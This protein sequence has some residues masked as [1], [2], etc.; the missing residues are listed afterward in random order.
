MAD[1]LFMKQLSPKELLFGA[2]GRTD[3]RQPRCFVQE[4]Y[5]KKPGNGSPRRKG[6]TIHLPGVRA[7][8]IFQIMNAYAGKAALVTALDV[9]G[10]E[11]ALALARALPARV[12]GSLWIKVGLELFVAA[13]PD[14]LRLL[15]E[16]FPFPIFLDLKFHDIPNTVRSACRSAALLG[17]R[18]MNIHAC[19]GEAMAVAALE[20]RE[21]GV[22]PGHEKPLLLAVTVLTSQGG[23]RLGEEVLDKALRARAWGLD[24]V[25]CSGLE[26]AAVKAAC[27]EKF[28]CLCPGIRPAAAGRDDQARICTPAQAVRAGADFLVVGRPVTRAADPGAAVEAILAEMQASEQDLLSGS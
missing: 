21:Q 23:E 16:D 17:V 19:G 8:A 26:A 10:R 6:V 2:P 13:G 1:S 9:P 11:E 22:P 18:M 24:G 20:G 5:L 7:S 14:L 27:G 12:D 25:V 3:R 28:I 15:H 4:K